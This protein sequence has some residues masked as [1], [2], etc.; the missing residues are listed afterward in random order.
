MVTWGSHLNGWFWGQGEGVRQGQGSGQ[1]SSLLGARSGGIRS[2]LEQS[3]TL[4]NITTSVHYF[5]VQ[6]A[7]TDRAG[8]GVNCPNRVI[9]D[10]EQGP[11][12]RLPLPHLPSR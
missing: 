2:A 11:W 7:Q 4:G 6:D 3:Q 1:K 10:T 12:L 9:G 5:W 8:K